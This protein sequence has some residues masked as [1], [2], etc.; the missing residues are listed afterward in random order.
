MSRVKLG[1]THTPKKVEDHESVEDITIVSC[2]VCGLTVVIAT[3]RQIAP[4]LL[5][6]KP[7]ERY[8]R[9]H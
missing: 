8:I 7:L 6:H 3:K 9:T 1:C 5:P 4:W 2:L